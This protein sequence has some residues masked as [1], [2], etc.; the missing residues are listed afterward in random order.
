MPDEI[1]DDKTRAGE[2]ANGGR[3]GLTSRTRG[4]A[5]HSERGGQTCT[6]QLVR[7]GSGGLDRA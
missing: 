4:V 7:Y 5:A 1:N 3:A 2:R 6:V